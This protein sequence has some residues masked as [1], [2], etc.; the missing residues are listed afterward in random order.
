MFDLVTKCFILTYRH[1]VSLNHLDIWLNNNITKHNACCK[2]NVGHLV[3]LVS[4]HS[5]CWFLSSVSTFFFIEAQFFGSADYKNKSHWL[6][7]LLVVN[8]TTEQLLGMFLL[9][10]RRRNKE[11]KPSL[12]TSQQREERCSPPLGAGLK[13]AVSIFLTSPVMFLS[14]PPCQDLRCVNKVIFVIEDQ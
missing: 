12:N 10:A 3:S 14:F 7:T 6:F 11:E 4:P 9:F 2:R 13:C 5:L 8:I 1:I